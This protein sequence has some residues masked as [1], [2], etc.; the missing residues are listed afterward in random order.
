MMS[1]AVIAKILMVFAIVLNSFSLLLTVKTYE[2]NRQTWL[3]YRDN[4][5]SR[6]RLFSKPTF[7]W[8]QAKWTLAI[9]SIEVLILYWE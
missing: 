9:I 1:L 2:M 7:I 5:D 8:Y 3:R 6:G 4:L